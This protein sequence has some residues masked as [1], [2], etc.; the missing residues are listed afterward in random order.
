MVNGSSEDS[1]LC[2]ASF[3]AVSGAVVKRVWRSIYGGR[4]KKVKFWICMYNFIYSL[5]RVNLIKT[6]QQALLG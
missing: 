1:V 3:L 4:A 5:T 6:P 2:F